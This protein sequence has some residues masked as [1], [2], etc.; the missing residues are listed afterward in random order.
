MSRLETCRR[1]CRIPWPAKRGSYRQRYGNVPVY[2]RDMRLRFLAILFALAVAPAARVSAQDLSPRAYLITPVR[3]NAV[4]LTWSFYDGGL[5]LNGTIPIT[6][7]TGTYHVPAI[8]YYHALHFFGRSANITAVLPYGVGTFQ[9]NVFGT[10]RSV[11]RSGLLDLSLRFS[12]NLIG[13]PAMPLDEFLKW[14]QK[15]LLG[16]SIKV[17]APTGQ[18]N[19]AKLVNWGINRWA[20]KPEVGYSRRWGNWILDGYGGVWFFTTNNASFA[21]P[22][23]RPQTEAPVGSFEGHLSREFWKRRCW[24]SLDGNFWFGGTTTL[25]G[26]TRPESR[27]TSSRLGGTFA[28]PITK[29][30]AL[31]FAYSAGTYIRFGGNYQNVQVA[32][33]YS[34]IG[35][36]K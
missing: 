24:A 22:I 23:P 34:W 21:T 8:G 2:E 20:F 17:V 32:W 14:K 26:I 10:Q 5:D 9:G 4:T 11:Y 29:H 18:Y 30:Q 35:W 19:G 13:G 16:A 1:P 33:Q 27:Q 36:P 7:A 15:T 28:L 3:S 6:G 31:K 12:V 25:N